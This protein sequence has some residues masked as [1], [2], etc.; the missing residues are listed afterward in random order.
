M[1]V[2]AVR[3][4]AVAPQAGEGQRGHRH[5]FRSPGMLTSYVLVRRRRIMPNQRRPADNSASA[6]GSGTATAS[7]SDCTFTVKSTG[8]TTPGNVTDV[9]T[10]SCKAPVSIIFGGVRFVGV[11]I[12][13]SSSDWNDA[14]NPTVA[15]PEVK[16]KRSRT[17][18]TP[19]PPP[20]L[21]MLPGPAMIN[22]PRPLTLPTL[23][24]RP[25]II[26]S[27]SDRVNIEFTTVFLYH[28]WWS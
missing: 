28:I 14:R 18:L 19:C 21:C 26:E 25:E 11:S 2:Q 4:G 1:P 7:R 13:F 17:S 10:T 3:R 23:R 5:R 12:P 6:D 27:T 16:V 8:P 24:A 22:V 9:E 20:S 15:P